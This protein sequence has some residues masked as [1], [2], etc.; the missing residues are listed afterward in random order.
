[1]TQMGGPKTPMKGRAAARAGFSER[2]FETQHLHDD[3][4]CFREMFTVSQRHDVLL[5][6]LIL[7][8]K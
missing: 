4:R 2:R 5:P 1:M 7:V 8:C 6:E 3:R